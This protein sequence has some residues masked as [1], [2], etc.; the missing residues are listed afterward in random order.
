[1]T[2][3]TMVARMGPP[4]VAVDREEYFECPTGMFRYTNS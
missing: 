2:M 1:V 4:W 3:A